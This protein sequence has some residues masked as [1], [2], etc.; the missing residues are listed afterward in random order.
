LWRP[1]W[2]NASGT[3]SDRSH[4]RVIVTPEDVFEEYRPRLTG[5]SYHI[6]GSWVDAEDVV[7]LPGWSESGTTRR[8]NRRQ[9]G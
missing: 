1:Y 6:L 4:R 7:R 2:S 9:R 8:L 5:T 3:D